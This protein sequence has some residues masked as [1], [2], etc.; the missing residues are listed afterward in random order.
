[1][2][3][4][5]FSFSSLPGRRCPQV[6]KVAKRLGLPSPG[7]KPA[8]MKLRSVRVVGGVSGALGIAVG[9]ILGMVREH[10]R[11]KRSRWKA[12]PTRR[13]CPCVRCRCCSWRMT[14]RGARGSYSSSSTRMATVC[15]TRRS[16]RI[17]SPVPCSPPVACARTRLTRLCV[18]RRA[19]NPRAG[20]R[21]AVHPRI[22]EGQRP[23]QQH[24]PGGV[25]DGEQGEKV[26]QARQDLRVISREGTTC[27]IL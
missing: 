9:C 4:C 26:G 14:T 3:P 24:Q 19:G 18:V 5:F 27:D 20:G 13:R 16:Y 17:C 8:Q 2:R 6:E 7:L 23:P 22:A 1:M 10:G 21:S 11:C 15:W 25:P 12:L